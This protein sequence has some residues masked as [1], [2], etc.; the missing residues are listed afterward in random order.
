M[1][2]VKEEEELNGGKAAT[3]TPLKKQTIKQNKKIKEKTI[4]EQK[5]H[6]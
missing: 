5:E 2:D 4:D 6:N 1:N 3:K